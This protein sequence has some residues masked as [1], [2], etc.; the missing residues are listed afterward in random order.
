[1]RQ[2][3]TRGS[4]R[5]NKEVS[6]VIPFQPNPNQP[7]NFHFHFPSHFHFHFFIIIYYVR[8]AFH[9]LIYY[10]IH[11]LFNRYVNHPFIPFIPF[12]T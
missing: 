1:M 8:I 7:F 9:R 11:L 12:I 3:Q 10:I 2:A 4:R 6:Q 5:Q